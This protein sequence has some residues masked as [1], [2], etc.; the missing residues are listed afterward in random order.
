MI[1]G[2]AEI[3]IHAIT[4][5]FKKEIEAELQSVGNSVSN[6]GQQAGNNFSKS[7]SNGAGKNSP[8]SKFAKEADKSKDAFNRLVRVGYL[9]GPAIAGGVNAVSDLISGLFA[10][11]SAVGSA[12]PA[13]AVL[14]GLLAAV[15][16]G[17]IAA[18]LAFGGI[19]KAVSS[20]LKPQKGGGGGANNDAAVAEARKQLARAYQ[21]AADQM[22]AAND[23]VRKAQVALNQAY[24]DGA[25]ALQ[26]L[27]FDAEDAAIA[28]DKAAIQLERARESLLRVQDM[29]PDSRLRRE[30][31]LAFK[32]ADLN[33][34]QAKDTASD[35]AKAQDYAKKTGIEGTKEVIG[36]KQDL[37]DAEQDRTKTER[38]NAQNIAD[39]QDAL[40]KA[41]TK[42]GAAA[43]GMSNAFKNLSPEA[44]RFARYIAGLAPVFYKLRAA[45]GRFLFGPLETAIQN[46]VDN[47]V[48]VLIPI[49]EQTGKVLGTFA[50]TFSKMLSGNAGLIKRVFGGSNLVVLGNL[51]DAFVNLAQS[52]LYILDAVAPLVVQF[53]AWIKTVTAGWKA[54]LG[55]S[56]ASGEL[57]KKFTKAADAAKI[58]GSM[59]KSVWDA[60]RSLGR[61]AAPAGLMLIKA[62]GGA[63]D[64]L[65]A[66]S[67][68]GNKTGELPQKFMDI[69]ENVK[70]I[71]HFVGKVIKVLFDLGGNPGV[72][73]FFETIEPI[74]EIFGNMAKELGGEKLGKTIGDLAVKAATFMSNFTESGGIQNFFSVINKAFSIINAIFANPVVKKV[75]LFVAAISGFTLAFGAL[76]TVGSFAFKVLFGKMAVFGKALMLLNPRHLTKKMKELEVATNKAALRMQKFNATAA[77][78]SLGRMSK[79]VRALAM[80]FKALSVQ[81]LIAAAPMLAIAAVVAAVALLFYGMWK[82]SKALRDSVADL[83]K[84]LKDAL[85]GAMKD[86]NK[87]LATINPKFT[88]FSKVLKA[89]GD[90]V[91]KYVV[92]IFKVV[93]VGA[94]KI[95]AAIIV[96]II[97]VIGWLIKNWKLVAIAIAPFIALPVLIIVGVI[98]L[99]Q[100]IKKHWGAI[101][102]FITKAVDKIKEVGMKIWKWL[103]P[104]L[105]RAWIK[106]RYYIAL[107]RFI[108]QRAVKQIEKIGA[109]IWSWL[110]PPLKFIWGLIFAYWK[111]AFKVLKAVITTIINIGKK[112][113]NFLF[114]GLKFVWGLVSAYFKFIFQ[115]IRGIILIIIE[116]GKK[117]W[118]FLIDGIKFVWGLAKGFWDNTVYPFFSGIVAAVV[119][120]A[121]KVWDFLKDGVTNAWNAAKGFWDKTVYPFFSGIVTAISKVAGAVWDFLSTRVKNVWNNA[122]KFWNETIYPFFSG[123]ATAVK[124]AAGAVW[125]FLT[126]KLT[127]AWNSV[128]NF[129]KDTIEPFVSGIKDKITNLAKGMWD[130]FK[131]GLAS[132]LNWVI[133]KFNDFIAG[134]NGMADKLNVLIPGKDND[135]EDIPPIPRV[136]FAAK[137]GVFQPKAGGNLAVL[138]EAGRPER[139]EP[140]DPQ[141]LSVRDRAIIREL[142]GG[143]SGGGTTFVVNPSPGMDEVELSYM[144]ARRVGWAQKRGA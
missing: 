31:E 3:V 96:F 51:G 107:V 63:M 28:E 117:V 120:V 64:K 4:S 74:P 26:Q 122:T 92:P 18:K 73:K 68:A 15:A 142:S 80:S 50:V 40:Q 140:L 42:T 25:E 14:P 12:A 100:A 108:V 70:A 55:A 115:V 123:I 29:P 60:M 77:K 57:T 20:L 45:A 90:W 58:I 118:D 33:Y 49:L 94:I 69:A 44:A 109:K 8:F 126:D 106:V 105:M 24:R 130:G 16:Q 133:D 27:G 113:W 67:D 81:V 91:A 19:G 2:S 104:P 41:L 127:S 34:R 35:L 128:K 95:L 75:F 112:I 23:K 82:N 76:A 88:D 62:F 9:L 129:F 61:A 97:K 114:T 144:V 32:E 5:G 11:G 98:K 143:G 10:V 79:Q 111:F 65:K 87:A 54:T 124:N 134:V 86:I 110:L 135:I 47:L 17:A 6:L 72:K 136:T 39:A 43:S 101:K 119:A 103:L 48:P 46:L 22:A 93:L 78:G 83:G 53:S 116:I 121:S 13:L 66:F 52:G 21:T 7:F 36:A 141:G 38:D 138:A 37:A 131:T 139:V 71:G 89:M 1:I 132:V 102:S 84:A 125:N 137:G 99:V 85:G 59:L 30:A 56:N